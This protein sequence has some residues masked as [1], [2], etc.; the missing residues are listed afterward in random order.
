MTAPNSTTEAA[1]TETENLCPECGGSGHV[2]R[3]TSHLGPDDYDFEC[4]CDACNG[5]GSGNLIEI[6]ES[7]GYW[8][9]KTDIERTL[10]ERSAVLRILKLATPPATSG[11]KKGPPSQ[12]VVES[13]IDAAIVSLRDS[14]HR[15][16]RAAVIK[17]VE[18]FLDV[19]EP[20]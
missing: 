18:A 6:I 10:I 9:H 7:L 11:M 17:A 20:K 19:W 5:T 14:G 16:H 4:S 13:A 15:I 8:K 3:S 2:M 1:V 12:E